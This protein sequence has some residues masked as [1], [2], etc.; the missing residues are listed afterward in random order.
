LWVSCVVR[1]R[2]LRRA[3]RSSRGVLPTVLRR[4]VWSGNIKNMHSI[5][6]AL[7]RAVLQPDENFH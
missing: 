2:S 7:Q 4:C 5:H 1:L 6:Y 3:D